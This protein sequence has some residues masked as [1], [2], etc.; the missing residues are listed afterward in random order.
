MKG[1]NMDLQEMRKGDH[2]SASS[3]NDYMECGLLYKLSRI[4]KCK[5]AFT[6]DA[7][8]FGSSIHKTM[9]DFNQLRMLGEIMSLEGLHRSFEAYWKDAA[10]DNKN[11]Q[12]KK[13]NDFIFLMEQ[14]KN[15][16][17]AFH[18]NH[19][20]EGMNVI[21]IEE[22]FRFTMDGLDVP[23]VG[24]FDLIEEDESGTIVIA[25]YKTA[26][27]AYSVKDV[28][29]NFQMML[30]QMAAK[31]NG[32][33]DRNILLRLDC[34]IKTKKAK[35]E[36]YYTSRSELDERRALKKIVEVWRGIT[37][38]VF[39][40]ND[41]SWRCPSCAYKTYCDDW[42]LEDLKKVA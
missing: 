12:Y 41:T 11:I 26:A 39:I 24:F 16:L 3:I 7:L 6:A 33:G 22:P 2:L 8:I 9:A 38:G 23:L 40:P 37:S 4:D 5:P 18:G 14:G 32:Y 42:F 15:L 35:F 36:Q 29:S 25:D 27:K 21:A 13:G 28:S 34:L 1:V 10:E 31:S 30:Y 20:A 17:T 19:S